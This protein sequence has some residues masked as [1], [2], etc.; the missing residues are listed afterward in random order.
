ME[1]ITI[2]LGPALA[3]RGV[4]V[5]AP[6]RRDSKQVAPWPLE[7]RWRFSAMRQG[8]ETVLSVL[9]TVFDI[10]RPRAR[11]FQGVVCRIS[12]RILAYTLCIIT[13]P[14]LAHFRTM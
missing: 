2:R 14:L 9:S 5:Y 13:Q 4:V 8:V 10:Q 1:P 3:A 7:L 6:P 11:S 12:T